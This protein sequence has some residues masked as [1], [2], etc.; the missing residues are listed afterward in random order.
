LLHIALTAAT[1]DLE[2]AIAAGD[3]AGHF[4]LQAS[5]LPSLTLLAIE[6]PENNLSPF[7]LPPL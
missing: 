3:H 5:A 2:A 6:E 4:D 1:L 7:E